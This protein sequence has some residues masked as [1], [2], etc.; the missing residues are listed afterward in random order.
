MKVKTTL[1]SKYFWG[2]L[3]GGKF[4]GLNL[5]EIYRQKP[6]KTFWTFRNFKGVKIDGKVF[7]CS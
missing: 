7:N 2:I 5:C 3:Q 1:L 4:L 6:S